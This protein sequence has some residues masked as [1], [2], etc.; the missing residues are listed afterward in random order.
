MP[1]FLS[2]FF[3]QTMSIK[4]SVSR[5]LMQR[6]LLSFSLILLGAGGTLVGQR[7][8]QPNPAIASQPVAQIPN[9]LNNGGSNS[10]DRILPS[11]DSNFIASAVQK[12]GPAVVLINTER[13][14]R[15]RFGGVPPEFRDDPRLRR[16]F[17][18]RAPERDQVEEGTGSGFI[19]DAKGIILTNAHVVDNADRVTV[20]LK[21]G[22]TLDGEVLGKDTFTDVAVV[23]VNA[24]NLPTIPIGDSDQLKPGEWA[25]A[26]GNPLGL[27]NTVTAGIISA[28]GRSSA[29]VGVGDRRVSFIQT[30]AAINPGNSGGP[31]LNQNG[32]VVGMNTAILQN[33]QGLGFA[34]PIKT[35]RRIADQLISKGKVDHP[36]LGV[37]MTALTPDVQQQVNS[38]DFG[39]KLQ[40]DRGILIYGVA[41]NSP[42]AQAGLQEGDVIQKLGGK[43]V[44]RAEQV[45]EIVE[46]SQI[47]QPLAVELNRGGRSISLTISPGVLPQQSQG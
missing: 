30:D 17:G 33:A 11:T 19:V 3:L 9:P 35:A 4:K 29:E 1:L 21:D 37:R 13:T 23:K 16:F 42:A 15:G 10:G 38:S 5:Q 24:D 14:V 31:L 47:G 22:R 36:Y 7:L 39:I 41:N 18:G 34:V 40:V 45:Q 27:E 46:N 44:L 20:T 12:V 26:I 6:S 2:N 8:I 28:T 43:E 25:I 32:E